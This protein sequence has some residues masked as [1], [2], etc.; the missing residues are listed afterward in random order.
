MST[1]LTA[2]GPPATLAH[3]LERLAAMES[4]PSQKRHDLMSAV[5]RVARL[6]DSL[7]ADIPADPESL[8]RR[9]GILSPSAAGMTMARWRNVRALLT[10]ALAVTGA[11]VMRGRRRG[12]VTPEWLA[13]L[14]RVSDVYERTRLSR[15]FSY[16][17]ANGIEPN[18]VDDRT[19]ADF[20]DGLKRNSLLERQTL[21][22]RS[23]CVTWNRCA[24]K[25][26]GWPATRLTVPN[27][28]R[29]F[30]R[31]A[32]AYPPS[33]GAN[34]AAYLDHQARGDLFGG[35][36]RGPASPVT[37][38]G[39]R[40]QLFQMAAALVESGRDPQTI[41]SVADLVQPEAVKTELKFFWTRNGNRKTGQLNNFALTAIKIAKWWV[42]S[43]SKQ[44]AA[45]QAIRR[46]VDPQDTGMTERNRA[47]LR[48]FDDPENLRRLI[49]LPET[50]WRSMS[51]TGPV[52]Y[53]A[54]IRVQSA[55][56][57]G[58]LLVAP[59]RMKNLAALDL[60]RHLSRTRPGGL[61]HIVIP[62]QEVKNDTP[63]SFEIPGCR[64]IPAVICSWRRGTGAPRHPYTS[65]PRSN[66]RSLERRESFSTLTRS[67]TSRPS[68]F[69]PR[70]RANTR[71]Y[72]FSSATRASTR[73]SGP[74]AASNRPMHCAAS[75]P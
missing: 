71:P 35:T 1:H 11:R 55:L 25:I 45:L 59:M 26:E 48:Q 53:A 14:E 70:I 18:D 2:L 57:I 75:T 23:L 56:A 3:V 31:P 44:I 41:R 50:I 58:I 66:T 16:S 72:V 28:R 69:W 47:R 51:R 9:L 68:F 7:P 43:P 37:I 24:D 33:F 64:R 27:R 73:R 29:D 49:N 4:L 22:V 52:S 38:R 32:S 6:L 10:A 20:A 30:A 46:Q 13:L 67:A 5:R 62:P 15:F 12:E 17:S 63:L 40:L 65:V 8:K 36:G 74:I 54:A 21:I 60:S 34:V 61:R 42:K 39:L 19:V